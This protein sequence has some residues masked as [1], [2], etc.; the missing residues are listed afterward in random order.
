MENETDQFCLFCAFVLFHFKAFGA[1]TL[2]P[3]ITQIT[4]N[5]YQLRDRCSVHVTILLNW[6]LWFGDSWTYARFNH[7]ENLFGLKLWSSKPLWDY[8]SSFRS[9]KSI[10]FPIAFLLFQVRLLLMVHISAIHIMCYWSGTLFRTNK[11]KHLIMWIE[12]NLAEKSICHVLKEIEYWLFE[13][14]QISPISWCYN[15]NNI[16]LWYNSYEDKMY[17][18]KVSWRRFTIQIEAYSQNWQWTNRK[19][20]NWSIKIYDKTQFH[21]VINC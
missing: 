21:H 11:Y 6:V 15:K 12:F 19:R 2:R 5:I 10:D 16:V 14:I 18:K 9:N 3:N 17:I 7:L 1:W 13:N 20:V 4:Y 8:W